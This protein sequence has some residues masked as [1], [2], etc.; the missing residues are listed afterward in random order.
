MSSPTV[1]EVHT[2]GNDAYEVVTLTQSEEIGNMISVASWCSACGTAVFT[3]LPS[4]YAHV[5]RGFMQDHIDQHAPG[6]A[7]DLDVQWQLYAQ[8]TVCDDGEIINEDSETLCCK[9]CDTT[10][11]I[12]GTY[13]ELV[14]DED[15]EPV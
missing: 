14:D 15:V 1:Y 3:A 7:I 4:K 12:D 11:S 5:R 13:G 2:G 8:C 10:W 9:Q 6:R